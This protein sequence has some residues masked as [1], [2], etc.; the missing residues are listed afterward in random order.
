[1][2][3]KTYAKLYFGRVLKRSLSAHLMQA[4]S[5]HFLFEWRTACMQFISENRL[6]KCQIF[7]RFAESNPN[8]IS[9]FHTSYFL[10]GLVIRAVDVQRECP[11]NLHA[12][13]QSSCKEIVL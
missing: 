8:R 11:L 13:L 12:K 4:S 1:L 9:V 3:Y 10:G 2:H 6:N 7:G 5:I